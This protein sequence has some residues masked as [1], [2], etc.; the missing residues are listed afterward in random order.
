[1]KLPENWRRAAVRFNQMSLRER[2]LIAAAG[3]GALVMLW[4]VAIMDPLH[5]HE[6]ALQDE[7]TSLQ[8]S[9]TNGTSADGMQGD[10]LRNE[11]ALARIETLNVELKRI[12]TE[13]ASKSAGLIPPERMVQAIQDVLR[14]QQGLK[15]VSLHNQTMTPL[16]PAVPPDPNA[17]TTTDA[18]GNVV[19]PVAPPAMDNGPFVHPVELVVEGTYLDV[20]RYL[21]A[22]EASPWRFDW[23]VLELKTQRYPINRVRIE[24]TTLSMDK[25]WVGV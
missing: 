22:L 4:T 2:L 6:R 18:D 25:E 13:L 3:L 16:V 15:L 11:E 8:D 7:M 5:A 1:M 20:L 12:D 10:A 24:L 19:E 14:H 17:A 9:L 23:K 21:Q